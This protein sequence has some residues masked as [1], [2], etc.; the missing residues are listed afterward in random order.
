VTEV[1]TA[2]K[3]NGNTDCTHKVVRNTEL[4]MTVKFILRRRVLRWSFSFSKQVTGGR[5]CLILEV[6]V[7]TGKLCDPI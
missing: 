2:W 1:S 5:S 7:Q 4:K 3:L 6:P